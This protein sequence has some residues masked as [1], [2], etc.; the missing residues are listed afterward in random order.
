MEG[1]KR[2]YKVKKLYFKSCFFP[3]YIRTNFNNSFGNYVNNNGYDINNYFIKEL[4]IINRLTDYYN[5]GNYKY[6]STLKFYD[7]INEL[8]KEDKSYYYINKVPYDKNG[9]PFSK[10]QLYLCELLNGELN[11]KIGN[12]YAD[13]FIKPNIIIEYDGS[14]H[15]LCIY[16]GYLNLNKKKEKDKQRYKYFFS[17]GYNIIHIISPQD[18][19][20]SDKVIFEQLYK[21]KKYFEQGHK[22]YEIHINTQ[23]YDKQYGKLRKII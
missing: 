1:I 9:V 19:L 4:Y 8:Q 10:Q 3:Q 5:Y 20:P 14:G 17:K 6:I 2:H 21:A 16:T 13:I 15:N 22:F 18:Y 12:C 23:V 11:Y 7:K